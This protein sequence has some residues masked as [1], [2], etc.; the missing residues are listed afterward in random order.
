MLLIPNGTE[1]MVNDDYYTKKINYEGFPNHMDWFPGS[2][3]HWHLSHHA[4]PIY[5]NGL[6]YSEST[7][8]L[9]FGSQSTDEDEMSETITTTLISDEGG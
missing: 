9:H 6:K 4:T 8:K 2:I 7:R 3:I 5:E 1:N